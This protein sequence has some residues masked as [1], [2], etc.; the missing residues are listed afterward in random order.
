MDLLQSRPDAIEMES[1]LAC[2]WVDARD[3][4]NAQSAVHLQ[5]CSTRPIALATMAEPVWR[6]ADENMSRGSRTITVIAVDHNPILLE[7]IAVLIQSQPDMQLLGTASTACEG[8]ALHLGK[9]PDIAVI[10][11]ELPDSTALT[12]IRHILE[13][14]PLAKLIGLTTYEFDKSVP[15]AMAAGVIAVITKDRIG[16][17][18]ESLIRQAVRLRE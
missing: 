18:L 8:V 11:L 16:V 7:G 1:E 5:L 13:D 9:S 6:S 10:D 15:E 3:R 4:A 17:D 12:A 14:T 2:D